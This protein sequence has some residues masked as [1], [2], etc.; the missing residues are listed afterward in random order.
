MEELIC[1]AKAKAIVLSDEIISGLSEKVTD[2]NEKNKGKKVTFRVN[3]LS[4]GCFI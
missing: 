4:L 2:F 1:V 3:L